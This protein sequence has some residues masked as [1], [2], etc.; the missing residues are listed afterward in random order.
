MIDCPKQMWS[1]NIDQLYNIK[2]K[3]DAIKQQ[4]FHFCVNL[5]NKWAD[6]G[7]QREQVMKQRRWWH[8]NSAGIW[9][10]EWTECTATGRT[11]D[12]EEAEEA[13]EARTWRM[14]GQNSRRQLAEMCVK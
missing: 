7:R 1:W 4:K 11:L 13:E 2:W 14:P 10:H 9:T 8:L 5:P 3:V 12:P 6:E